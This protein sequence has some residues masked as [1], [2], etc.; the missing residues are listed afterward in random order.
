MHACYLAGRESR[1]GI[2][3]MNQGLDEA[4]AALTLAGILK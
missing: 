1:T 4:R 3:R 2:T